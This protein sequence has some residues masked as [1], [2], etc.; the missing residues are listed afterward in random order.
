MGLNIFIKNMYRVIALGHEAGEIVDQLRRTGI[1]DDIR[2]VFCDTESNR[3]KTHGRDDDERVL[4]TGIA[5]CREAIHE[6]CELMAV[7]VTSL[8]EDDSLKYAMEIMYELWS[9]ADYTYCFATTPNGDAVRKKDGSLVGAF[10][11]ITDYSLVTVLQD[12]G[13][14]PED[15]G[16][17]KGMA[18]LLELVLQHPRKGLSED[19][20]ES[21]F[22]VWPTEKQLYMALQAMYSNYPELSGYYDAEVFSFH[23]STHK[24]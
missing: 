13:R 22:G 14:L 15:F 20:D 17:S 21:P 3:L 1:Y 4:L 8:E 16:R 7:L 18:R 23:K 2:F 5:Q 12:N 10:N 24:Y 6:D 9:Y 19:R 11:W